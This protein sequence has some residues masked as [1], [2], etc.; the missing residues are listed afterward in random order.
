MLVIVSKEGLTGAQMMAGALGSLGIQLISNIKI[1]ENIFFDSIF[2]LN[3]LIAT[4]DT[5]DRI[6]RNGFKWSHTA[7]KFS[8]QFVE[9]M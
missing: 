7:A 1:K 6:P 5:S 4:A 3:L 9:K 8:T 2:A